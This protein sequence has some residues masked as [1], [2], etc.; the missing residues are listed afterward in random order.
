MSQHDNDDSEVYLLSENRSCIIRTL[1]DLISKTLAENEKLKSE[2]SEA[3]KEIKS[4]KHTLEV[5]TAKH[6]AT[7]VEQ[8]AREYDRSRAVELIRKYYL[9]Q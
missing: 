5:V 7:L 1:T 3:R 9:G 4:V 8:S 2:L 6:H